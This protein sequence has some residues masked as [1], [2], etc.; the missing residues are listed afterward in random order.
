M[1]KE[2]ILKDLSREFVMQ[3][4]NWAAVGSNEGLYAI[5]PAYD[6]MPVT[7]VRGSRTPLDNGESTHVERALGMVPNRERLAVR[8][9]WMYEGREMIWLTKRLMLTDVRTFENRVIKGHQQLRQR[10][11]SLQA[12]YERRLLHSAAA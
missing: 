3:M 2:A 9:F 5:S 8:L 4:R 7:P 1:S 12:Q 10:L 11:A 6:G